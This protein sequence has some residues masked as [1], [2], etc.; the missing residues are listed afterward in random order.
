MS[1][2]TVEGH[3]QKT[4]EVDPIGGIHLFLL[5][6]PN[7]HAAQSISIPMVL[8]CFVNHR[9]I[10]GG[11][12][13]RRPLSLAGNHLSQHLR[14]TEQNKKRLGISFYDEFTT[15]QIVVELLHSKN[16]IQTLLTVN[17]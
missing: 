5:L 4:Q 17:S 12:G 7:R 10:L 9:I 6:V 13:H 14:F 8:V 1:I 11:Q 15:I 3:T 2:K 16:L